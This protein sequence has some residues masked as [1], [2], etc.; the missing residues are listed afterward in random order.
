MNSNS[1]ILR[2]KVAR[3]AATLLYSGLEKEYKQAKL[4]AAANLGVH[5]LPKNIEIAIELDNIAE[6]NEGISRLE[7]LV[8]MRMEALKL[9]KIL[10]T[11]R[12]VLLGSVWRGTIRRGSD[13]DIAVY[14]DDVEVTSILRAQKNLIVFRLEHMVAEEQGKSLSSVHIH[15]VTWKKY[16]AEV[17]VRGIEEVG[18]KRFCET[19]GDEIRGLNIALLEKI[20]KTNPRQRF[21]PF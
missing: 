17:V 14:G 18:K 19:F 2:G 12:P 6:E 15:L 9:M 8:E 3:E 21:V 16:N 7:R 5:V 20:L 10:K 13:I 11:Y 1:S 4:K